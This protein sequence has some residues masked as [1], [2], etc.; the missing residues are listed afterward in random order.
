MRGRN[1]ETMSGQCADR[2]ADVRRITQGEYT[3][4]ARKLLSASGRTL[5]RSIV[6][7]TVTLVALLTGLIG[8]ASASVLYADVVN[9]QG[10][11]RDGFPYYCDHDWWITTGIPPDYLHYAACVN[12]RSFADID[13]ATGVKEYVMVQADHKIVRAQDGG[14]EWSQL[15]N[16]VANSNTGAGIRVI[17]RSVAS[18]GRVTAIALKVYGTDGMYCIRGDG[19]NWGNFYRC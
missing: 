13:W 6:L 15:R 18:N 5:R 8:T 10:V 7:L 14:G 17:S 4:K 9:S 1:D 11:F 16:G 3:L 12:G 2:R 19:H